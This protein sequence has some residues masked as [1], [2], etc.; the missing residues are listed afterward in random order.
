MP[1]KDREIENGTLEHAQQTIINLRKEIEDLKTSLGTSASIIENPTTFDVETEDSNVVQTKDKI[2]V[3]ERKFN[4][5]ETMYMESQNK[6]IESFRSLDER[7]KVY[8]DNI[9]ETIKEIVEKSF[10]HHD[11]IVVQEEL[12]T[13]KNE[14][15]FDIETENSSKMNNG[16]Y[17]K[18]EIELKAYNPDP[19]SSSDLYSQSEGE[20]TKIV[21]QVDVHKVS[22]DTTN[23]Q[24]HDDELISKE[25]AKIPSKV[26]KDM[27][28]NEFEQRLHQF[29]VDADSTGL[30]TPRS[31]EVYQDLAEEREEMKKVCYAFYMK[32]VKKM[33]SI[34]RGTLK[35]IQLFFIS[36]TDIY[37]VIEKQ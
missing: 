18:P 33:K 22:S 9:Q 29:G 32:L 28:L 4:A 21:C 3:I 19:N 14:I 25:N 1:E 35:K 8:M 15:N 20:E 2:D 24:N 27:A 10:G 26:F 23:Q 11:E 16:L 5:F 30:T 17:S 31:C 12:D 37:L 34:E 6:F 36:G 7:H 13:S